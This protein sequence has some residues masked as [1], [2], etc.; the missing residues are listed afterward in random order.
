[1]QRATFS[2]TGG[3]GEPA[4]SVILSPAAYFHMMSNQHKWAEAFDVPS[5]T[6]E[7]AQKMVDLRISAQ[8]YD[9]EVQAA[10][11]GV[12]SSRPVFNVNN[13]PSRTQP[14]LNR[15]LADNAISAEMPEGSVQ[16]AVNDAFSSRTVPD[17]ELDLIRAAQPTQ[18]P[19][20][21]SGEACRFHR[22][23]G[24]MTSG[25]RPPGVLS[26]SAHIEADREAAA[27]IISQCSNPYNGAFMTGFTAEGEED[28]PDAEFRQTKDLWHMGKHSE[29]TPEMEARFV[30]AMA[31]KRKS[32]AY[33]LKELPGYSG[34]VGEFHIAG[35][36]PA[37]VKDRD[38]PW[39]CKGRQLS[40]LELR[41]MDE[42]VIPLIEAGIVFECNIGGFANN[43]LLPAKKDAETGE[44]TDFRFVGDFRMCNLRVE[45]DRYQIP[46]PEQ[47]LQDMGNSKF[48]SKLDLRSGYFQIILAEEDQPL[49][50]FH[51]RG[52]R[53]AYRRAAQGLRN[54]G[55][56]SQRVMDT[57]VQNAGLKHC[58]AVYIDDLM[59]HSVTFDDHIRDV[60][61]VLNMLH[62]VGLRAH[63][64]KTYLCCE[65]M[66]FLGHDVS[67]RGM[68]PNQA[69]TA[70]IRA[71]PTPTDLESL[72]RVLGFAGYYRVY[73][74][75]Y[76]A[77]A[78]PLTELTQKGVVFEMTPE[79]CAAWETLK[80]KLCD[81]DCVLTRPK[82]TRKYVLHTDFSNKGIAAVLGQQYWIDEEGKEVMI[83]C[84]SRSLNKHERNY[85]SYKGELLA[86][87]WGVKS[88]RQYLHG[89]HF[90]LYT[91]HLPLV[92][93][94]QSQ[95]LSGQYLR[96]S[97][98]LSEYDFKIVH[99]PGITHQ[100]ADVPS[101][102]PIDSFK[103]FTGARAYAFMTRFTNRQ[104]M[105][106]SLSEATDSM[107][108]S[109]ACLALV[110]TCM[111]TSPAFTPW[112]SRKGNDWHPD[113]V[114]RAPFQTKSQVAMA[115][116]K[117]MQGNTFTM[118]SWAGGMGDDDTELL[119][120]DFTLTQEMV[121]LQQKAHRQVMS[122][123]E[124]LSNVSPAAIQT[125]SNVT[126]IGAIQDSW[127]VGK[128]S[129]LDTSPVHAQ[130]IQELLQHGVVLLELF[131]GLCAGLEMVLAN[132][133]AV[134]RY[135]DIN[136][137][138]Q[139][140]AAHRCMSLS[141]KYPELFTQEAW[142]DA[143]TFLPQMFTL[144]QAIVTT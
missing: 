128:V 101:R 26:E 130:V 11:S 44:Y 13:F 97:W 96:W 28:P 42:K 54:A 27:E 141:A 38:K 136:P 106:R 82:E 124:I 110:A 40:P 121:S 103:D 24:F 104:E 36:P 56:W 59:I 120:T 49:T 93:L 32:F 68:T 142:A 127:G 47:L 70:A 126:T 64:S 90:T 71:L 37:I 10:E 22:V 117:Y 41:V 50:A 46:V 31:D 43:V 94:M 51:Y 135:V 133:V 62:E 81:P 9:I 52:K 119:N 63:P 16:S 108:S 8:I 29:V 92:A 48:F 138:V 66:S 99:K 2:D 84:I 114:T 33:S 6:P 72:R 102:D 73:V 4:S 95:S 85:S 86:C 67:A 125:A 109:R 134:H 118:D 83:A 21:G 53:Y 7:L 60:G 111:A 98:I 139:A 112:E 17:L 74:P 69:K 123:A 131:G 1:M 143:V 137:T 65:I 55:P 122:C 18:D 5:L 105:L 14:S 116:C 15:K 45:L 78:R 20:P 107:S 61:A 30:E 58:C 35:P 129:S 25:T 88:Y 144:L 113:W 91:D 76:A 75:D 100:N 140:V 34:P 3:I 132:G 12:H 87:V 79:R 19:D 80:D 23:H 115:S 57:T 89:V 39:F 77:I